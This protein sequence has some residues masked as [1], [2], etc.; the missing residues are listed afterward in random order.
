VS[1]VPIEMYK[2]VKQIIRGTVHLQ[3]V[4][5]SFHESERRVFRHHHFRRACVLDPKAED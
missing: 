3:C 5:R 1:S 4:V 2:T